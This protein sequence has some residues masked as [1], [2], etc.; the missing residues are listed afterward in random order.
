MRHPLVAFGLSMPWSLAVA[1]ILVD[2]RVDEGN[3][4]SYRILEANGQQL[5]ARLHPD[6]IAGHLDRVPD[7]L[8]NG[9]FVIRASIGRSDIPIYG[10]IR[11]E[12]S[13]FED[14]FGVE[15]WYGFSFLIPDAWNS[16]EPAVKV[17]QIHD[18]ADVGENGVRHPTL[19]LMINP[20]R[21]VQLYNAYDEDFITTP[22]DVPPL[23]N[24]D[25]TFRK[26]AEWN[27]VTGSWVDIVIH[28]KWAADS[29]GFLHI[30]K[31][32]Q[33]L[34]SETDH[35]NT[36]NDQ[37]GVWFKAGTY[38]L[39]RSDDWSS[40]WSYTTG[41]VVGDAGETFGSI[42]ALIARPV[43]EPETA[44]LLTGGLVALARLAGRRRLRPS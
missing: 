27:L 37:R 22:P 23:P 44:L 24:V 20:A 8:G 30:W 2:G 28:A 9:R 10:G 7:P 18:R 41:V 33:L 6:G 17:F 25:Y 36:F 38:A 26:L 4:G 3:F 29:T 19:Q 12:M 15:R 13:G 5:A 40:L 42:S 16:P 43:P 21:K 35:I 11:S 14:P 39:G 32:G 31:D 34:H 1:A